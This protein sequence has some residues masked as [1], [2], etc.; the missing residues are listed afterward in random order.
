MKHFKSLITIY[1]SMNQN[2][3]YHVSPTRNADSILSK[4]LN[5][6]IGDRSS[7]YEE[8]NNAI[9]LFGS[10]D[11][12]EDAVMNWLGDE[13]DDEEQ[14]ALF[15]V[16]LP[17]DWPIEHEEH[18]FEYRSKQPIPPNLIKLLNANY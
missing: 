5:P 11:D 18:E 17:S 1:E 7:T 8:L 12:A 3:F 4:G 2:I 13:F 10:E 14:L 9:Y 16:T 6:S 15:Q